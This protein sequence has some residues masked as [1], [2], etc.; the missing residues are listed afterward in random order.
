[1]WLLWLHCVCLQPSRPVWL[2]VELNTACYYVVPVVNPSAIFFYD[3]YELFL[4]MH[5]L[6]LVCCRLLFFSMALRTCFWSKARM[7]SF[8]PCLMTLQVWMYSR[9]SRVELPLFITLLFSCSIFFLVNN[10]SGFSYWCWPATRRAVSCM[11]FVMVSAVASILSCG[12]S[13]SM[14]NLFCNSASNLMFLQFIGINFLWPHGQFNSLKPSVDLGSSSNHSVITANVYAVEHW[15]IREDTMLVCE[16]VVNLIFAFT[17][18]GDQY[19]AS[20]T[21]L[22]EQC[23]DY[24]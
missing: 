22:L 8:I 2:P 9:L 19:P 3:G 23:V 14:L 21:S 10:L 16:D 17:I 12:M 18:W 4:L 15:E 24:L 1:M 13:S 11:A 7:S 20:V 6:H 5:C